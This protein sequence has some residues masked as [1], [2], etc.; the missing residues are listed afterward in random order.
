MYL[1]LEVAANVLHF[2]SS[3]ANDAVE[4]FLGHVLLLVGPSGMGDGGVVVADQF[5]NGLL[6]G[7]AVLPGPGDADAAV[8]DLAHLLLAGVV[9]GLGDGDLDLQGLLKGLDVLSSLTDNLGE[10]LGVHRHVLLGE[11]R[12]LGNWTVA[13]GAEFLY[14]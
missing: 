14:S 13:L 2:G 9:V 6:S 7:D 12:R 4:E 11:T 1:H 3:S 8:R 10:V 5:L